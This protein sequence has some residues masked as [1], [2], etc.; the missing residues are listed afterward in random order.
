MAGP[1]WCILRAAALAFGAALPLP[2]AAAPVEL[3]LVLAVD[4][5]Q[6]VDEGE[7][8]L[9]MGGI[10]AA[11]RQPAVAEAAEES[12]DGIA[13]TLLQWSG[14]GGHVQAVPWTPLRNADAAAALA[15]R[16]ETTERLAAAGSTAIGDAL[17]FSMRLIEREMPDARRKVIDISGDG[18]NNQGEWP[19]S[20][21]PRLLAAGI[22]V[23][24]LAITNEEPDLDRYYASRVIGGPGAFVLRAA[25]F[26]AFAEAMARK[27][28]REI[29]GVRS[30][31]SAAASLPARGR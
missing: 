7:F 25:D 28:V 30:E 8:R 14:V 2:L 21:R 5:S 23:N 17:A 12:R 9:Q 16:I 31:G 29:A 3:A 22:T 6:S 18:M 26:A 10:A 19:D 24:G 13:I 11:L 27:L 4:C 1:G 15:A 20:V